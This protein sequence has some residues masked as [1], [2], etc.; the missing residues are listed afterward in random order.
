MG[1]RTLKDEFEKVAHRN[2]HHLKQ[3]TAALRRT[4]PDEP[5]VYAEPKH[6]NRR[7]NEY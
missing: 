1:V 7:V 4:P 5:S 2:D 3:I 6:V